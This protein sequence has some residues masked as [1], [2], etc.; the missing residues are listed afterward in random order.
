MY[1]EKNYR[2]SIIEDSK[3]HKEWLKVEL[4]ALNNIN[5]VSY[6]HLTLPTIALV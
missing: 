3:I 5:A 2:I 4:S 1:I 6:T